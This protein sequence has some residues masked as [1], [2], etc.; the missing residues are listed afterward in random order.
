[1]EMGVGEATT[2]EVIMGVSPPGIGVSRGGTRLAQITV[3][4][5]IVGRKSAFR[6]TSPF[7]FGC[8]G[9]KRERKNAKIY[10]SPRAD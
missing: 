10:H 6:R 4:E 2:G 3:V 9:K 7:F 1:M 8:G 5:G